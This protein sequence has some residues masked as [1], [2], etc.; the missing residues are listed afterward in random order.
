MVCDHFGIGSGRLGGQ[1][2]IR[3]AAAGHPHGFG[4]TM[5]V[6]LL[7]LMGSS[8]GAAYCECAHRVVEFGRMTST[9]AP[10]RRNSPH[11]IASQLTR[12]YEHSTFVLI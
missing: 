1:P 11:W 5:V 10:R 6:L 2:T 7:L 12:M 9:V 4:W 3:M 8:V